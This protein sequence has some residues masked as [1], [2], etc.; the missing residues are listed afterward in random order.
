VSTA[1]K[2]PPSLQFHTTHQSLSVIAKRGVHLT[3]WHDSLGPRQALFQAQRPKSENLLVGLW[4]PHHCHLPLKEVAV[5]H[6]ASTEAVYR[7][8]CEF[9]SKT[10]R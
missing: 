10:I 7:M 9:W 4:W 3:R 6:Q 1:L 2:N 8:P 5:I